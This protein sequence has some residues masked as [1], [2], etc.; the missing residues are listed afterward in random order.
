LGLSHQTL[1]EKLMSPRIRNTNYGYFAPAGLLGIWVG[2]GPHF[3]NLYPIDNSE[4]IDRLVHWWLHSGP[5]EFPGI[6]DLVNQS[7]FSELHMQ[8]LERSLSDAGADLTLSPL[9][10]IVSRCRPDIF[11]S[12][13]Q[14]RMAEGHFW[15]WWLSDGQDAYNVT[16][17]GSYLAQMRLLFDRA[18]RNESTICDELFFLGLHKIRGASEN[19]SDALS[20]LEDFLEAVHFSFLEK[21]DNDLEPSPLLRF[22]HR[23]R[24][25]VHETID[26]SSRQGRF[27]LWCWWL[28]H[29]QFDLIP[30]TPW[31]VARSFTAFAIR[32]YSYSRTDLDDFDELGTAQLHKLMTLPLDDRATTAMR[33]D[34][35]SVNDG[36]GDRVDL[37]SKIAQFVWCSRIDLQNAFDI[38]QA[39]DFRALREW[40]LKT[41][42][43]EYVRTGEVSAARS[44]PI[45]RSEKIAETSLTRQLSERHPVSLVGYPRGEFGLGEDIRLLRNSLQTTGIEPNVIR[46]PW[47]I[48]A[49]QTIEEPA[50]EADIATFDSEVMLYVMPAFDTL[51]LLNKVGLRAFTAKRKIGYWQWELDRFPDPAKIAFDLIDEIWC[52]S[53]HSA[54]AFRSA[55]DKPVVKVPLPVFVPE[56]EPVPRSTFG[57]SERNYIVFSSFDGASSIS[58]KNPMGVI[59]AF[60]QAFPT[61]KWPDA[62][63]VIKAMNTID[64]ALWRECQRKAALDNRIR[65]FD[66]VLG[67]NE[68]YELLQSCDVVLSMHRA[69]GFGRVMAEA[70]ALEIP[71]VASGYSG[72][73][74]FMS[75]ENSWL[76]PGVLLPLVP[77]D[78]PFYQG[79]EWLEPDIGEAAKALLDCFENWEKRARLVENAKATIECYSPVNCGR[80]YADLLTV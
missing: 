45:I 41:G 47:Q 37:A 60:Q 46:A 3:Q 10:A 57:F 15:L 8:P 19:D 80:F 6:R 31:S 1:A 26:L 59:L 2:A 33:G 75:E 23:V 18:S 65:I 44:A 72:N 17:Y 32:A 27:E 61:T 20:A 73:L 49:R 77:G 50:Q 35:D 4:G 76:V 53:E 63:L 39:A 68:Y 13:P 38:S 56:V 78:Y 5:Q 7:L 54:R 14:D 25:D 29:G 70:M 16:S 52:H 79:Q 12:T 34:S 64:D 22:V 55:T 62:R 58:R 74:D 11:G 51:T 67:R 21:M 66:R 69:E 36:S 9:Q 24:T 48:I 43:L 42:W 28:N 30:E 71:T 40:W